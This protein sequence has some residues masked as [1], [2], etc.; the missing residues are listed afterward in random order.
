MGRLT[1]LCR[2]YFIHPSPPTVNKTR[3]AMKLQTSSCQRFTANKREVFAV[4]MYALEID[5]RDT[6]RIV[7]V[8]STAKYRY[9]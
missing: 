5:A 7:S 4:T 9:A 6:E 3:I 8:R 1:S 2:F